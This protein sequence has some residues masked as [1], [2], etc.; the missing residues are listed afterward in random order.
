MLIAVLSGFVLALAAPWVYQW[1][2]GATGWLIALLPFGLLAYFATFVPPVAD[3]E[4]FSVSY[5]WVPTLGISFS[6]YIDGLSLLFATLI[7]GIGALIMIYSGGYLGKHPQIGRF[8]LYILMF[9]ASMLGLV[10]ADNL[11]TLFVFWEMTSI[12]SYLL[13]GFEH[14]EET[15]RASALQ[16]LLVTGSGGLALLAG[17]VILGLAGGSFELSSLLTQGDV[18]R[19]HPLYLPILLLV[20]VGAFTKSAQ[21][22]F[23][24]W[25]PGAMAAPTPVSAYLHSATMVKA[26]IYLLARLS[27]VLGGTDAWLFLVTTTGTVTMVVGGYT[28]LYQTDLKRILAYSTVSALGTL[29]LL[30]GLGTRYAI[31]GAMVFLLAHAL[32]KGALFMIAGIIDHETGTRDVERLGGLR[33]AMPITALIAG[34]AALSLGGV[35][36]MLSFIGKELLLEAVLAAE[37]AWVFLVPAVVLAGSFFV[38]VAAIVGIRPFFGAERHTPKH[39]H[40]APPSL[41]LGPAVLTVIGIVTGILPSTVANAFATPAVAAVLSESEPVTLYLWHG[42]NIVLGLS[43]V[44]VILGIFLFTGWTSLRRKT[45]WV[46]RIFAWGPTRW[47]TLSLDGM[48]WLAR[49]QTRRLQ[50]GYL[51]YYLLTIL[52]TT[53]GLVGY[54]LLTQANPPGRLGWS[55]VR[56]YE[57]AL[58]LL[59]VLAAGAA[60]ISPSRLS[61]VAALGVVGYGIA[62]IYILFG[63]PDLAMTQ[64]MVETLTVILF[65]LVFYHMPRF[66]EKSTRAVRLRDAVVAIGTGSLMTA[67]VLAAAA[68]PSGSVLASYFAENS[69]P[70]AHGRNIVNVILVDYRAMDTLGEI[71]VLAVA[72]SGVFALLKLRPKK[73]DAR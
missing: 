46:E 27:P 18:V 59:I 7:S 11:L 64:F 35:G 70:L 41:W 47:Y 21:V 2:R 28:A 56:F 23:H 57:L 30:L 3:G 43:A 65:V 13:V 68:T 44:S 36:P 24:F 25:L 53:V 40:E 42:F 66:T 54:T 29:T 67:L 38:V 5:P 31:I 72:G 49:E 4:T 71:T 1:G 17:L 37:R 15:A 20:L 19:D 34:F 61:A 69:V 60:V 63:A 22:P 32:Y 6:F 10:T 45:S 9:M 51:R 12:S 73:G 39:P 52:V 16:A 58:A 14:E 8:Y 50:N 48:N 26:G 62:L 55:S 33:R